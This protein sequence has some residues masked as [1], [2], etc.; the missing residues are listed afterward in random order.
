MWR[1]V[2]TC[3]AEHVAGGLDPSCKRD[4]E[5]VSMGITAKQRATFALR[6]TSSLAPEKVLEIIEGA[7]GV[8]K[9]GGKSLLTTGFTNLGAQVNIHRRTAT[10]LDLSL[11]SGKKLV[12]LGTLSAEATAGLEG[13][14][15]VRIGGLDTYKTQ[16]SKFLFIIPVGP[17]QIYG[18][19]LYKRFLKAVSDELLAADP[20]AKLDMAQAQ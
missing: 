3:I 9:G 1:T 12:E 18:M 13:R 11:T 10:Q 4:A 19:D 8:A 7:S 15:K 5:C 16:Q 6:G 20:S 17:K 14:T 2:H